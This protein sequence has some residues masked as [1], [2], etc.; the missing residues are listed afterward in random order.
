MK[1]ALEDRRSEVRHLRLKQVHTMHERSGSEE[2]ERLSA[3]KA[4]AFWLVASLAGWALV[5]LL[6]MLFS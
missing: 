2:E 4:L 6:L 5:T 1:H 3:G